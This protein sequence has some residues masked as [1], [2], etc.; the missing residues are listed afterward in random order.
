M[1]RQGREEEARILQQL[2]QRDGADDGVVVPH[3][4]VDVAPVLAAAGAAAAGEHLAPDM[5]AMC[6]GFN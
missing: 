2:E 1:T 5:S 6:D 4:G 3:Q